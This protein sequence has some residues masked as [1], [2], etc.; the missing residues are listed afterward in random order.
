MPE[1]VTPGVYYERADA[2][3]AFIAPLRTDI[4]GFVGIARRGPVGL[5][6]PVDG[7]RQFAAWF[8]DFTGS[9]YLAY[10]ARGFFENGGRR[11]W[12]VRV[13]GATATSAS[14]VALAAPTPAAPPPFTPAWEVRASSAGVWGNDVEVEWRETHRAQIAADPA[15]STAEYAIVSS[16]AGFERG[17]HVRVFVTPGVPAYRVV[18]AVDPGRRRLYWVNPQPKL[19]LSFEQPL[20]G[21]DTSRPLIIE[22]IEYTL[23]AREVGKLVAVVE[24][25]SLSP[26]H[27]RYGPAVLAPIDTP[28]EG[29]FNARNTGSNAPGPVV[30]RE[31]RSDTDIAKLWPLASA[32]LVRQTL[33]G[34]A[35]GLAPLTARDFIGDAPDPFDDI[36]T[37]TSKR[38]GIRALE[39]VSEVAVVAVPDIHIHAAYPPLKR[40]PPVCV[41]DPCL[42]P[43]P[44]APATPRVASIGD[45]PPRFT[46]QQ[47]FQV[48]Q[49]LI[50]HCEMAQDRFALLSPPLETVDDARLGIGPLREWRR[51]FDSAFGAL[52]GPWL[53][54]PDPLQL[55]AS[56]LRA[57]P[58]CGHVAGF[59]AQTDLRIGV[60]RAPANGALTWVQ[61]VTL[62]VDDEL[63]GVLNP[64]NVNAIRCF[65]GRGLRVFGARTLSSDPDWRFVNVRRLL[66]MIEKAIRIGS[67]WV[68]FEPNNSLTRTTLHLALTS[69]LL[70]IWRRG[71]L[72]GATAREAFYVNCS[73]TQNPPAKRDLGMLIAEIGIAPAKPFEFIVVRVGVSDNALEIS[74]TGTVAEVA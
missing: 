1:Y 57:I 38:R 62:P 21:F 64:E 49:A 4:A 34:G 40:P 15:L 11:C 7:W 52:Y 39:P 9:G 24:N 70:E 12:I 67:Q 53:L 14:G 71:A 72:A 5:A 42:P 13:A 20:T 6:I 2:S 16:V 33:N 36:A 69:L 19:R 37:R 32:S 51:R 54:V 58:P 60:H 27:R 68:T 25:L 10:A 63:H 26:A 17:T 73:E 8:G 35:D 48:Q 50:D 41:P 18:S 59:I 43:P 46:E 55:D 44:S 56:G 30:L 3:D 45:L 22:S 31:L 47:I 23:L 74:E 28:E 29:R 66:L 61:N 65:A